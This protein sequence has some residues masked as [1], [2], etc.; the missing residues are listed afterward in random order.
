MAIADGYKRLMV[1]SIE[2]Q[3]RNEYKEKADEEAIKVFSEN[4]R[5]L[6]LAAPLG[7]KGYPGP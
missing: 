2:N 3:I 1:P 5:Q 7:A 4:L 6:L